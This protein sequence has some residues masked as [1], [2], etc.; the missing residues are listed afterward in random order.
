[1]AQVTRKPIHIHTVLAKHIHTV[2]AN[3]FPHLALK[4]EQRQ[5]G[6]G[7]SSAA[8]A[9]PLPFRWA[10]D[11]P[12]A[13]NAWP[14][15]E[16]MTTL[17][18]G[19]LSK[20]HK[21]SQARREKRWIVSD[22]FAVNYS[23][24]EDPATRTGRFDLRQVES[25]DEPEPDELV[26]SI[27]GKPHALHIYLTD[28]EPSDAALFRR[29]W[30][31]GV[32]ANAVSLALLPHRSAVLASRFQDKHGSQITPT[33]GSS[34]S[35]SLS[36]GP[37]SH[38]SRGPSSHSSKTPRQGQLPPTDA[39]RETPLATV[40][41]EWRAGSASTDELGRGSEAD[42][43][44]S[45]EEVSLPPAPAV[46]RTTGVPLINLSRISDAEILK[47]RRNARREG[48]HPGTIN[49]PVARFRWRQRRLCQ[50]QQACH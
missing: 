30:A 48:A 44:A 3:T 35:F 17:A 40:G 49:R 39:I 25:I 47:V 1:M 4:T 28:A 9:R 33:Y 14:P 36:R 26:L 41:K 23:K 42:E 46:P 15:A 13:K 10:T 21:G 12:D 32:D 29:L 6:G 16:R 8:A 20:S 31:S 22:G 38:L 43:E 45:L 11:R 24:S 37:S 50:G 18:R 27:K 5:K 19:W 34:S 7:R 2:L